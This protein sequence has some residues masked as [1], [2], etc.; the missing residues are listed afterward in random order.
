MGQNGSVPV[1]KT[2]AFRAHFWVYLEIL[3]KGKLSMFGAY[4]V[5]IIWRHLQAN[6]YFCATCV[7]RRVEVALVG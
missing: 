3:S 1:N 7:L 6:V 5:L 2:D 4:L